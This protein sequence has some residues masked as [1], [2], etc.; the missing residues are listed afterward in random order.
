MTNSDLNVDVNRSASF[1]VGETADDGNGHGT[2]IAGIIAAK[3]NS[4]GVVG[5]APGATVVAINVC[6]QFGDCWVSHVKAG[7]EYVAANFASGDVA[8]ISLGYH[9]DC[10]ENPLSNCDIALSIMEN[11]ITTAANSG[12]IFTMAAGNDNDLSSDYSPGRL[13]H[14]NIYTVSAYDIN[15]DFASFSNYGNPPV[16]YGGPGVNITSLALNGGTINRDGTSFSAPHIA[17]L[18]LAA[19]QYVGIGGYV[20]NDPDSNPDPILKHTPLTASISGTLLLDA[21]ETG[22]W[23]ASASNGVGSYSYQ[24]YF[25]NDFYAQ[26]VNWIADGTDSK[27]Y[28]RRF[29][30]ANQFPRYAGVKVVVSDGVK[31]ASYDSMIIVQSPDCSPI[32]CPLTNK[33]Q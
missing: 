10:A 12:V 9:E 8:N 11:S 6:N 29:Q 28:S 16:D 32:P 18:L 7:V 23:Q 30:Y 24:W 26:P 3:D 14:A 31:Q 5:V 21:G 20:N 15:D 1:V 27:Y 2:F 13:N 4:F 19:P 17:G 22:N 25:T 33:N